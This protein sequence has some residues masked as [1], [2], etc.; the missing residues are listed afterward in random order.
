MD[1]KNQI[2][3]PIIAPV[4]K[5]GLWLMSRSRL[6]RVNGSLQIKGLQES[7][8]VLRDRWG[9]PHIYARSKKDVLFA[10]GFIHAQERFWQ[11]D[12]SRRVVFGRLSEVL[13]EAA[14]PIDRAM[15]TLGMFRTAEKEAVQYSETFRE[16]LDSYC[17]GINAWIE[18][19]I[20]K[21]SCL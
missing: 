3:F 11:M 15:R 2:L 1:W 18:M 10:Q 4:L 16:L 12:F 17:Q 8:E 7:V 13:G 20:Q 14:L 19:A 21:R 6:P 9:V 5:A